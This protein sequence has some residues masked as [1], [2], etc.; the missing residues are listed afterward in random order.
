MK[1]FVMCSNQKNY[2]LK[3]IGAILLYVIMCERILER[4]NSVVNRDMGQ[5]KLQCSFTSFQNYSIMF[6]ESAMTCTML[7]LGLIA[8]FHLLKVSKMSWD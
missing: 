7:Y 1:D 5:N 2:Q 6:T 3:I 4:A 8:S